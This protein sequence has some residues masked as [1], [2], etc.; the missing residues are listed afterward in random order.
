MK[1][2]SDIVK[3]YSKVKNRKQKQSYFKISFYTF[4]SAKI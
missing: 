2:K 1:L 3:Y 4:P